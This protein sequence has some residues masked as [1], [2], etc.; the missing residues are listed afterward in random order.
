M[1]V[2]DGVVDIDHGVLVE[3]HRKGRAS[4]PAQAAAKTRS[5]ISNTAPARNRRLR[6]EVMTWNGLRGSRDATTADLGRFESHPSVVAGLDSAP[7]ALGHRG[8][9][10]GVAGTSPATTQREI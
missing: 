1:P 2:P 5:K 10:T 6:R 8:I 7:R 9:T 3:L 4:L